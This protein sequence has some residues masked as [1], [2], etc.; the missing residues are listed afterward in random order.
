MYNVTVWISAVISIIDRETGIPSS[1]LIAG[2]T[3]KTG[4]P[5]DFNR[6]KALNEYRSGLKLLAIIAT[7][8]IKHLL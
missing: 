6:V 3:G 7:F 4:Y 5:W 8:F 1:S 2:A